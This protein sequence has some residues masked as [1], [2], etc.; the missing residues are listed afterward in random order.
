METDLTL[1]AGQIPPSFSPCFLNECP[2]TDTCLRFLAGK[3]IPDDKLGGLA[4]YPTV[5]KKDTCPCYK[6]IRVIHAAY[7]FNTL[8]KDIKL[9]D[10]PLCATASK[11]MWEGGPHTTATIAANCCSHRNNKHGSSTCSATTATLKTCIS[12]DTATCTTS[13][14]KRFCRHTK[15]FRL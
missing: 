5:L 6:A 2:K 14:K 13:L 10:E 3:H 12:T 4:I 15:N 7:G 11:P 9:K 1:T 8:F